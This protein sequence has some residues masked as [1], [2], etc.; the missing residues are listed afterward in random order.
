MSLAICLAAVFGGCS[1]ENPG[2]PGGGNN[3]TFDNIWPAAVG[4]YW[5]YDLD[6]RLYR[7]G[8]QV[9]DRAGDIPP[10]PT[11]DELYAELKVDFPGAPLEIRKGNLRWLVTA[12]ATVDPDTPEATTVAISRKA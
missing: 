7:G 1:D 11:M 4:Q 9:Y 2:Q 6:D 8:V 3:A 12:D 5:V 10:I